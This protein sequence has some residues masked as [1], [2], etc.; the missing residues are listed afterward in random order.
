MAEGEDEGED[1]GNS[2]SETDSDLDG[3]GHL[4]D[5]E[6][7][8]KGRCQRLVKA[9]GE[10]CYIHRKRSGH[11]RSPT[12]QRTPRTGRKRSPK[13][14]SPLD[15]KRVRGSSTD[16]HGRHPP[17]DNPA[18]STTLG[19]LEHLKKILELSTSITATL[20]PASV[21]PMS[22]HDMFAN[23]HGMHMDVINGLMGAWERHGET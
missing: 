18:G 17:S 1:E 16:S 9:P 6:T 10:H 13:R 20:Q 21:K 19:D 3:A 7:V 11:T 5:A 2:D 23:I 22:G 12:R 8:R 4:C 14:D 15:P